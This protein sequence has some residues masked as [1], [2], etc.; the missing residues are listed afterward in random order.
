MST[1]YA[2]ANVRD[3]PTADELRR[4][5]HYD[6]PTGV[7]R[8][9][10]SQKNGA[11][12][13][14]AVA[15]SVDGR[16]YAQIGVGGKQ[17]K[18][19]RLAWVYMTGTFPVDEIDHVDGDRTNNAW[20]NLRQASHKQNQENIKLRSDSSSGFRGVCFDKRRNR[21]IAKVVHNKKQ[22]NLGYFETAEQ[23]AEAA[24]A[25]RAEF[26]THDHGRDGWVS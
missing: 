15:G 22:H 3:H 9:R 7:F 23:A 14:W 25:K 1:T 6:P 16:G 19:H 5:V 24:C 26:F 11:I 10:K 18:A 21:W 17:L 4:L 20:A 8:W 12:P 13:P 2:I